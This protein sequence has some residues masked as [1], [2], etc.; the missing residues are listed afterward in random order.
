LSPLLAAL[1]NARLSLLNLSVIAWIMLML[2][3]IGAWLWTSATDVPRNPLSVRIFGRSGL[4]PTFRLPCLLSGTTLWLTAF[5]VI[6]A[7]V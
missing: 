4:P 2:S 6:V 5:I 3:V 1:S 7:K